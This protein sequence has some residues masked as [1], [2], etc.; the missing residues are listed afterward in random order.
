MDLATGLTH[1]TANNKIVLSP[2]TYNGQPFKSP[3]PATAR[4][5]TS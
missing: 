1:A 3:I 5:R 4:F 2:G